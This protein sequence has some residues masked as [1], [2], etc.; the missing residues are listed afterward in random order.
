VFSKICIYIQKVTSLVKFSEVK[1]ILR[2][3]SMS[4]IGL[5]L[6]VLKQHL[7]FSA[8]HIL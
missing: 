1:K 6:V 4:L 8:D 3:R 2:R 7:V 5:R